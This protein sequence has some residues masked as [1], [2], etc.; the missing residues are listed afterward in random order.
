MRV[1][2]AYGSKQG[3]TEGLA[4]WL[5]SDL[6]ELGFDV[7]VMPARQVAEPA[8]YDAVI[9]GGA[10]YV[11]M[12]HRDTRWFVRRHR[13]ALQK[14]P[15]WLFSSGPLDDSATEKEIPPVRFVRRAMHRLG[16]V[17]HITFGGRLPDDY[18]G[19]LPVG[20]WRSKDQV[21]QWA[22]TIAARLREGALTG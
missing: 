19:P 6:E 21:D 12:W 8:I 3:G 17:G 9:V 13:K 16:A 4:R 14:L 1:L 18:K 7:D 10:V 5:G 11:S 2:V 15:V 22:M 20:D